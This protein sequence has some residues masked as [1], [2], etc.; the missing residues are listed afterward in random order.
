MER[1][2]GVLHF[3]PNEPFA[4]IAA[5][6]PCMAQVKMDRHVLTHSRQLRLAFYSMHEPFS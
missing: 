1:L 5:L 3:L 6:L 2:R 4:Y